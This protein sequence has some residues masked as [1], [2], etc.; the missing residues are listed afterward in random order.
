MN[1]SLTINYLW[2]NSSHVYAKHMNDTLN[3]KMCYSNI[4]YFNY[5]IDL[6]QPFSFDLILI[7]NI[8]FPKNIKLKWLFIYYENHTI[9]NQYIFLNIQAKM[10]LNLFLCLFIM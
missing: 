3:K 6:V 4:F 9:F 10:L 7:Q 2:S 1:K 8:Y 5:I